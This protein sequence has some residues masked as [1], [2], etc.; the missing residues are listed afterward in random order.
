[1]TKKRKKLWTIGLISLLISGIIVNIAFSIAHLFQEDTWR[2]P[3]SSGREMDFDSENNI[4]V[5]SFQSIQK[6]S[7]NGMKLWKKNIDIY[8]DYSNGPHFKVD[9]Q[10]NINI[11]FPYSRSIFLTKYNSSGRFLLERSF[12]MSLEFWIND[13][14]L[15][16][17]DNIIVLGTQ[18][19]ISNYKENI[20]LLEFNNIGQVQ[21]FNVIENDDWDNY[22]QQ[23]KI[24]SKFNFIICGESHDINSSWHSFIISYNSSLHLNWEL[25]ND[26]FRFLRIEVDTSD[27]IYAILY[28]YN[29][30]VLCKYNSE[31][32]MIWKYS[33]DQ[34]IHDHKFYP[35]LSPEWYSPF[36][37]RVDSQSNLYLGGE[38]SFYIFKGY[39][40]DTDVF[41]LK[42]NIL[43]NKT[44][45]MTWGGI[46]DMTLL[47]SFE[48]DKN[49]NIY[50]LSDLLV[51]NPQ[52]NGKLLA[53]NYFCLYKFFQIIS[54][55]SLII[56]FKFRNKEKNVKRE[57]QKKKEN[58]IRL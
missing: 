31:G 18:Y 13:I 14:A 57:F 42:I 38:Y 23:I 34:F 4:Y 10:D 52:N 43:N 29:V 30:S 33:I 32:I 49:N 56:I 46:F 58:E 47:F 37:I 6:F 5:I 28:R 51:K 20:F 24:D 19:N 7:C 48:I 2:I 40:L 36:E 35:N 55:V 45:F 17:K 44:V 39:N 3:S 16:P 41:I 12:E 8:G 22:G 11:I 54:I 9:S 26:N 21:D 1:M 50:V 27:N 25:Q 53:L 15:D